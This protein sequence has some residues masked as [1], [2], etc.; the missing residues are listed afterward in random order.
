MAQVATEVYRE[1]LSREMA[2]VDTKYRERLS[3]EMAQV[4][5]EVYRERL[6]REM[7]QAATIEAIT[8]PIS[9]FFQP[10]TMSRYIHI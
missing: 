2:Q 8:P 9:I 1:R 6:S 10:P 3:R 7:A 4:A 5:T